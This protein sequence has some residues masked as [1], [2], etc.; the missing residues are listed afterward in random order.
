M[1][2]SLITPFMFVPKGGVQIF[3]VNMPNY[4]SCAMALGPLICS[5]KDLD[6]IV[7]FKD[8]EGIVM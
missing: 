6:E 7:H 8:V 5:N 3:N 2:E 4:H 1:A